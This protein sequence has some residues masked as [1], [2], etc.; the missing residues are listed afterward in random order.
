MVGR[1]IPRV[2]MFVLVM[3]LSITPSTRAGEGGSSNYFPGTYGDY[4]VAVAP[5]QGWTY[6][7]YNLLYSAEVDRAALQGRLNVNLDTYAY[8]NMS[9]LIYAFEKPVIGAQ[10][11][12]GTFVPVGYA[13]LETTL[14][15][16]LGTVSLD[17]SETNLGDVALLP[18]SL[19]WNA[20]NWHFNFYELVTAPTGQYDIDNNVNLG[21]NYW[22]FDTVFSITNLNM[23]TGREFSL[24]SGYMH[25][26]ENDDTDYQTGGEL[27]VDAMFNQFLS[28]YFAI[29]LHGYY[30]QQLQGDSGNGAILGDFK[31]ESYGIGPS[32]LWIPKPTGGKLSVIGS[33]LHDLHASNRLESDYA[34][35]TLAW[36]LGSKN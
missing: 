14:M 3:A 33:W 36:Q 27:H 9:A 21:R 6:A 12:M 1:S 31:G 25:N 4:A 19:Y 24:V 11:A 13:D 8:I 28:D 23:E 2:N 26:S 20:D 7:N 15:G 34:V 30:Y 16:P 35:I 29:G 32:F 18:A 17:D 22:S 5:S 10:F